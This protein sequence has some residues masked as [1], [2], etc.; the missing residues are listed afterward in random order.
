MAAIHHH[1]SLG[2]S[3]VFKGGTCL[4]KCFFDTYRFSEDLDFTVR[5]SAH[6]DERFL[7]ESFATISDWIYEQSG[8][9]LPSDKM[10]FEVFMNPRGVAA[11]QGRVYYKGPATYYS[12]HSMPRI[13]L[14]ISSDEIL[15]D[16]PAIIPVRHDYS[17][18][19]D[20]GIR[21]LA[22]SY[23]EV[24]A[25]K[26]RALSQRTRPRDL[27]D[28]I[29]FY[30][31]PESRDIVEDVRSI[32]AEK[33]RFKAIVFPSWGELERQREVCSGGWENQLRH[34]LPSLPPFESFWNEL[35]SFFAW[36]N[37]PEHKAIAELSPIPPRQE[38]EGVSI[39]SQP[40]PELTTEL[41]RVRFA[42]VNRLCVELDYRKDNGQRSA[43]LIEPYSLR[44]SADGHLLLYAIKLPA[45][46]IRCF[47]TDRIL[48]TVVTRQSFMPR[49]SIDFIPDGPVRLSTRQRTSTSLGLPRHHSSKPT[50]RHRRS[51]SRQSDTGPRYV[52]RCPVCNKTFTRKTRRAQLNAH[53]NKQG[54]P[55]DGRTG[56][57]V[58][59]KY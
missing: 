59:T 31:R 50:A 58:K 21:I 49:Y 39:P 57:Y 24:F 35:P 10:K 22:Y 26:I 17:D 18:V 23:A 14:D 43:Y 54:R 47:R 36:L 48:G 9:E 30:R 16:A 27:Y 1:P 7:L 56:I 28:V 20:D 53:K 8:I 2:T 5:D 29:N 45:E 19:P 55:C 44:L 34:Q 25:E 46:E 37:D 12:K 13:K 38:G 4:K 40:G 15:V 33:C 32:L 52:F 41:D 3:W 6:I 51:K 42:A 11:C